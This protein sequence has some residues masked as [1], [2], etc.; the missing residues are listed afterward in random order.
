[1]ILSHNASAIVALANIHVDVNKFSQVLRNLVSNAL[2]FTPRGGNVKLVSK[3]VNSVGD[4]VDTLGTSSDFEDVYFRFE[5]HDTGPGIS[6]VSAPNLFVDL[7][8]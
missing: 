2:K 8:G 4:R 1:V 6:T 7:I 3:L 5:V